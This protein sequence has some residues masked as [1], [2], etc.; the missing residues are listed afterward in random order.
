MC[1]DS[2]EMETART[3]LDAND[4]EL[5]VE[6]NEVSTFQ[7][8]RKMNFH[9]NQTNRKKMSCDKMMQVNEIQIRIA[10]NNF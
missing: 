10:I 5:A 7:T 1:I 3:T 8:E 9:Q 6:I 4:C 2:D